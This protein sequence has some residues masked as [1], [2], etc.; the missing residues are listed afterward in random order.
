MEKDLQKIAQ[1][2]KLGNVKDKKNINSGIHETFIISIDKEKNNK[3]VFQRINNNLLDKF[4]YKC[5]K[6]IAEEWTKISNLLY[7]LL[8]GEFFSVAR[9]INKEDHFCFY[10]GESYWRV[11]E[12]I[13]NEEIEEKTEEIL[14]DLKKKSIIETERFQNN[15]KW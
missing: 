10:D 14:K 13:D 6:E 3:F 5:K 8:E 4:E 1:A 11:F 15:I 7:D 2:Y 9:A 12:Y